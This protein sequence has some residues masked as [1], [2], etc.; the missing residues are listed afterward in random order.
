MRHVLNPTPDHR[1]RTTR[2]IPVRGS[3]CH[4]AYPESN[5]RSVSWCS[6]WWW[7]SRTLAMACYELPNNE[8]PRGGPIAAGRRQYHSTWTT[9]S[10]H[11]VSH[12]E[13][14]MTSRWMRCL[15]VR[16]R[17]IVILRIVMLGMLSFV[18]SRAI[19][20]MAACM[21]AR[22]ELLRT[23]GSSG[24]CRIPLLPVDPVDPEHRTSGLTSDQ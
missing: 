17:G 5:T 19:L 9:S 11:R 10:A 23:L 8:V 18:L 1:Q 20:R 2:T 12:A 6:S 15:C 21:L 4:E 13:H 16:Y 24:L 3:T 7:E 14:A 22:R